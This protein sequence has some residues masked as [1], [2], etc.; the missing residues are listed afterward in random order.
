MK[1]ATKYFR[2][3][4]SR[5]LEY[6]DEYSLPFMSTGT[7]GPTR[8]DYLQAIKVSESKYKNL[9]KKSK[10]D[11]QALIEERNIPQWVVLPSGE[12]NILKET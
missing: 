7:R 1:P 9:N 3:N 6:I 10:A 5:M 8:Q 2:W 11:L 12:V 4:K